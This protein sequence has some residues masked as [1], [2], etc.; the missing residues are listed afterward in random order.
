MYVVGYIDD[1]TELFDDYISRLQDRD[2]NLMIA[3]DGSMEEVKLWIVDNNIKCMI[4]DH[5]LKNRY[6]FYGTDLVAYLKTELVGLPCIILT[7]YSD[8]SINEKLVEK[9]NI[10][11]RDVMSSNDFDS[12]CD[13]IKQC[14]EVFDRRMESYK[15]QYKELFVKKRNNEITIGEEEK[16]LDL[17]KILR[18]YREVDDVPAEMLKTTLSNQLDSVLGKLDDLLEK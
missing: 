6:D 7:S 16:L 3:P 12:F 13:T 15:S 1:D 9:N 14:T 10:V 4:V 11:E 8:D 18:A 5:R 2:I 17:F